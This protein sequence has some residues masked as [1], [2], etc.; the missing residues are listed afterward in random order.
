MSELNYK[1]LIKESQSELE[2]LEREQK[3]SR[4][5]D[6]VR[7]LRYLKEG[8]AKSQTESGSLIGLKARQSQNIWRIYKAQGLSYLLKEHR[9]GQVGQLSYV[10]ISQLQSL[11]RDSKTALTQQQIA[12]WIDSSFG[13][14]YTQGGISVLFKRLKI[15]LKTGRPVNVRQKEGD[16]EDFKKNSPN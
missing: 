7:Y 1:E 13:V 11:L 8:T 15:K 2:K 10:Q 6:Y 14:Q 9:R 5:R 4:F 16:I 12:D 3:L